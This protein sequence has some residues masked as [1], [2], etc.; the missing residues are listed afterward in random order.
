MIQDLASVIVLNWNGRQHLQRCLS[1]LGS[2]RYQPCEIILVDNGSSDGSADYVEAEFPSVRV[3]RLQTNTGFCAGNNLGI[4]ESR[5]EYVALINN[6]TEAD[7][8]WLAESIEALGANPEAGFTACRIRLFGDRS[9]LDT[10]GDLFFSSGYPGK[11]GSLRHDGPE[12][13]RN[14]WVFGASAAAAVYRR[15]ML[16]AIGLLDE[17]FFNNMEDVDLSFRA[18]LNG[19]RCLYV[20][21]AIVYHKVGATLGTPTNSAGNQY[22]AHRNHWYVLIKNLPP[23]LWLRYLGDILGAEA[24]VFV[25]AIRNGRQDVF[26]RARAD[27]FRALPLL[28]TKRKQIQQTR[29]VPPSYIDSIIRK[30]WYVHRLAERREERQQANRG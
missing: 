8:A 2:Q 20:S 10:A 22:Q 5:G 14:E 6:D 18:Q 7:P 3:I 13:D 1:S 16:D 12:F 28:L 21:S 23:S 19:Y 15:S 26:L 4:R 27:V 30:G 9:R 29:C 24:L 17:D 11:R 25:S